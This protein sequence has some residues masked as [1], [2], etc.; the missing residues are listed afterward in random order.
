M[1]DRTDGGPAFPGWYPGGNG[2]I[3]SEGL[4]K[5]ELFAGMALQG[6]LANSSVD[7]KKFNA[8]VV[9]YGLADLMIRTGNG[10]KNGE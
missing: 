2:P 3:W 9:A 7:V 6:I 5:R 1:S 8:V 10:G 4:S